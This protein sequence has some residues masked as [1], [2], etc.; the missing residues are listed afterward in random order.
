MISRLWLALLLGSRLS[1]PAPSRTLSPHLTLRCALFQRHCDEWCRRVPARRLP[2]SDSPARR[3]DALSRR[4]TAASPSPSPPTT[5]TMSHPD[6][7]Q[8]GFDPSGD[9]FGF[10]PIAAEELARREAAKE[11]IEAARREKEL[12]ARRAEEQEKAH[13]RELARIEKEKKMAEATARRLAAH[14]QM[15][16]EEEEAKRR[17]SE[18]AELERRRSEQQLREEE[19]ALARAAAEQ[20]ARDEAEARARE[21]AERRQQ[22]EA[23]EAAERRRREQLEEAERLA[24]ARARKIREQLQRQS[25]PKPVA[26]SAPSADSS[27]TK[28]GFGDAG[29]LEGEQPSSRSKG[30]GASARH[31][32]LQSHLL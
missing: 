8:Y 32:C 21:E 3:P 24:E 12:A 5:T 25:P 4:P 13:K 11:K 6:E 16:R 20:R 29:Q 7:V 18:Q 31:Q 30:L 15:V 1:P 14:E 28:Y 19:A 2:P 22:R 27:P 10:N 17:A 23:K 9:V 26:A